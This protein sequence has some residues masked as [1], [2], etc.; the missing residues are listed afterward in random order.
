[1]LRSVKHLHNATIGATDGDI[2]NVDEFLFDDEQW[3][4]RY[5]V[6]NTGDWLVDQLVLISPMAIQSVDWEHHRVNVNLPRQ[7]VEGAPPIETDQP[8][9]RQKEEDFAAHYGYNPYWYGGGIWGVSM[10]PYAFQPV[11][12]APID[13]LARTAE[14]HELSDEQPHGENHLRSTSEVRNYHIHASDD[15]IGHVSDFIIDDETWQI[16]YM[17]I[18]TSN[19]WFG[20]KVLVAPEWITRID[21]GNAQVD[22]SMSREQIKQGPEFKESMLNRTY[23]EQLYQHYRRP[24]YWE[25]QPP[26]TS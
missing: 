5:M 18:D 22:V 20:K 9:S 16:R 21:W 4:I 25:Q 24:G 19:W 12:G 2:G 10:T 26:K 3:T 8:V 14:R 17:V 6:V 11:P 7:K 1:M 23:E 15:E 13:V